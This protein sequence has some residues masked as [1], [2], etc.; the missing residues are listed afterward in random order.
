MIY[1]NSKGK[2]ISK[3][4]WLSLQ[5]KEKSKKTMNNSRRRKHTQTAELN[6]PQE[7]VVAKSEITEGTQVL[8]LG[9]DFDVD[10]Y[11]KRVE[12]F[13]KSMEEEVES[14]EVPVKEET[15]TKTPG[16]FTTWFK[17]WF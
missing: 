4:E 9:A 2:F 14:I 7:Q 11:K 16:F 3:E 15:P 1:R 13:E 8:K 5:P 6:A 10:A 12:E 17:K